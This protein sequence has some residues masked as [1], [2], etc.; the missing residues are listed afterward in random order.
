MLD[1]NQRDGSGNGVRRGD[2]VAAQIQLIPYAEVNG[3]WSLTDEAVRDCWDHLVADGTAKLVFWDGSVTSA[4]QFLAVMKRPGNIPVFGHDGTSMLAVAWL[5]GVQRNYAHAHFACF[6]EAWG[7]SSLDVCRAF[8]DYWGAFSSEGRYIF[9]V[10][11]GETPSHLRK[12]LKFINRLGFVRVGSIP[13]I[14]NGNDIMVSYK[15]M[16]D[17]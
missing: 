15:V 13:K 16:R 8:L 5:N 4:D 14:A 11:V 1:Q 12:A 2:G 17:G 7:R 6:R 3:S 9:D 10:V